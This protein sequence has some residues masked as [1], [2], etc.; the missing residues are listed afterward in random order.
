M[1]FF[2]R[3]MLRQKLIS[4]FILISVIPAIITTSITLFRSKALVESKVNNLTKQISDEKIAYIDT[5]IERI[6]GQIDSVIKSPDVYRRDNAKLLNILQNLQQSDENVIALYVGNS[7][8]EMLIYPK[9]QLPEGYDPTSRP[10]Y[11]DAVNSFGRAVI[12]DPYEDAASK[13]VVITVAKAF[14]LSDGKTAVVAAD[15]SIDTIIKNMLKTKVGETG[16]TTLILD[17]GVV[18]AHP[19]KEMLFVNIAE[20][21]DFGKK[22]VQMKNGNLKYN[23]NGE[24]KIMGFSHSKLTNWIAI[25]TMN[26]SEY[27]KEF[28]NSLTQTAIILAIMAALTAILGLAFANRISN[29]LINIMHLMK[30]AEKGDMAIDVEVTSS[31]EVG[32]IQESFKNMIKAQRE[33]IKKIKVSVEEV[34]GQSENLSATSEEMASSSQEVAKTMQ[35]IAEGSSSQANDLQEIVSLMINLTNSIEG[36]YQ[37]LQKVKDEAGNT[38]N[39]ASAGK[40]EMDKLIKSIDDIRNAFELVVAKVNN[41]TSSVKEISNI[42][43]VIT[44]ISEQT[45]LLALNAAI[46]AARA[47]EAGRGFAVVADEVRKL[48]EESKKST[49]EIAELVS[50]IQKDTED[51][52][53][54]SSSVENFIKSQTKAVENTVGAFGEILESVEGIVPLMEM[55]HRGMDEVVKS[56]DEILSKVEAVS[57]VTEENSAA[58]EEV[59]ASSEEL[60]ASSQ[61]VAATAEHLSSLASD[62]SKMVDVY[63]VE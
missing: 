47:G 13:D 38:S 61:E 41:L 36:A 3:M 58:A 37:Q 53:K 11:K 4:I 57:A 50:S 1:N 54:T 16:Y 14:K 2:K 49:S 43:S 29:P 62:L 28:N 45:N 5:F 22:V 31:D 56:K 21:Y 33:M 42:T 59:A 15:I 46:E 55:V 39:K 51:V 17:N 34:L 27:A 60:S 35:Q 32:R 30:R 10:W 6:I 52:I 19:K 24:D 40:E 8:K 25:A 9:I 7:D 44:S 20:K 48:A 12:T 23:F 18:I 26:Q 63:K